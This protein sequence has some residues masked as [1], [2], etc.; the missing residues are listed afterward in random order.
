M[1]RAYRSKFVSPLEDKAVLDDG[2]VLLFAA[3]ASFTGEDIVELHGHGGV[4]Q[5]RSLIDAVMSLGCEP[6]RPGEFS[7]R[8]VLNGRMDLATAEGVAQLVAAETEAGLRAAR[9]LLGGELSKRIEVLIGQTD[10]LLAQLEASLD[11]PDECEGMDESRWPARILSIKIETELLAG[12]WDGARRLRRAPRVVLLGPPNSGKSSLLNVL[13]GYERA[14][15][16]DEPGTTRDILEID[17]SLKGLLVT[18]V[19][20]AGYREDGERIELLGIE[21]L[22]NA[23]KEADLVVGVIDGSRD[24]AECEEAV[25][26]LFSALDCPLLMVANKLDLGLA[27]LESNLVRVDGSSWIETS[28]VT[29]EGVSKLCQ[30]IVDLL[31]LT[32]PGE[33]RVLVT[34]ER[35]HDALCRAGGALGEAG[36]L[37]EK[38]GSLE[39]VC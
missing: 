7:R 16:D 5:S 22:A 32:S 10:S 15:V 25:Y 37:L 30:E 24:P 39:V 21:R 6:A 33:G 20:G 3:P 34:L 18:L 29:E 27:G 26:E 14:I 35:H 8:A 28:A 9:S 12:T 38:G 13:A 2:L 17:V 23:A 36:D 11:F 4:A 1:R 31:N 19:D